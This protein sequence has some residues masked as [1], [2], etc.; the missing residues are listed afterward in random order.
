[1]RANSA[2]LIGLKMI[3]NGLTGFLF[4]LCLS[5]GG[6]VARLGRQINRNVLTTMKGVTEFFRRIAAF[7]TTA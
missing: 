2:A 6:S 5:N 4:R 7:R 1:M 3:W